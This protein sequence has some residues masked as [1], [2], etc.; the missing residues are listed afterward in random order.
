VTTGFRAWSIPLLAFAGLA[1]SLYL[2]L[3]HLRDEL[4]PC[5]GYTGCAD[6]NSSAYAY[7]FDIPIAAFGAGLYLALLG[8]GLYRM[9]ARGQP[10][11]W[12]TTLFYGLTVSGAVFMAYLTSVELFVLQAICYWCVALAGITFM[13]LALA[14]GEMRLLEGRDVMLSRSEASPRDRQRDPSLL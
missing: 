8:L 7:I 6:V 14:I 4:P 2:A 13:L 12:A 11:M 10:F 5:G 3:L 9:R 1:D